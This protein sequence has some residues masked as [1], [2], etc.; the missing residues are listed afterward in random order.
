MTTVRF[1]LPPFD[2]DGDGSAESLVFEYSDNLVLDFVVRSGY[3]TGEN[4]G[5]S[6]IIDILTD[7]VEDVSD[8]DIGRDGRRQ[9]LFTDLGGGARV[10][11]TRGDVTT[12]ESTHQWGTGNGGTWDATGEDALTKVQL[13]NEALT[14][15]EIDSRPA[16]GNYPEGHIARLEVG[17]YSAAGRWDP[18][19]VV[20]E[21]PQGT[22]DTTQH[23]SSAEVDINF[24]AAVSLDIAFDATEQ[25]EA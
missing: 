14:L 12:G 6:T 9:S 16:D 21:Q 11:E 3:L 10:V 25:S 1:E 5:G 8:I 13:L 18:L 2:I 22:F 19:K 24:V 20:P 17:E 23:S 4:G 15:A 7:L